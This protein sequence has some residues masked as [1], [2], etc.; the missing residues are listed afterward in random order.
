MARV[1]ELRRQMSGRNG[2]MP[3]NINVQGHS[4]AGA[5]RPPTRPT[6]GANRAAAVSASLPCAVRVNATELATIIAVYT[7]AQSAD[8]SA[9]LAQR[10]SALQR[11]ELSTPWVTAAALMR[12]ECECFT[13]PD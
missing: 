13:R 8:K 1:T 3:G 9:L 7:N 12:T 11:S 4:D 2:K 6:P 10:T 5:P